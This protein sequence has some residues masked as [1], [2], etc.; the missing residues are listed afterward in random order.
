ML[1]VVKKTKNVKQDRF[2]KVHNKEIS[3]SVVKDEAIVVN[4]EVLVEEPLNDI[5][6]VDNIIVGGEEVIEE[7]TKKPKSKKNKKEIV[8]ENEYE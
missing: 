4:A 1:Y 2:D 8:E 6:I 7:E 3:K 5:V